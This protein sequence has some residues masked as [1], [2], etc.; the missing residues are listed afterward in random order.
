[1]QVLLQTTASAV[2]NLPALSGV[3]TVPRP[4]TTIVVDLSAVRSNQLA[5]LTNFQ[6]QLSMLNAISQKELDQLPLNIEE[7]DFLKNLIERV[8]A[9]SNYRQWDGWYPKLF[10]QNAFFVRTWDLPECDLWDALVA[11]VHTDAP[12]PLFSGDPGAVIH[13]GV[14]NVNLLLI[15]IDN[16]PNRMVYAGPVLS[17]Y[18]FEVPGVHRM[19]DDEW[20][21]EL[22]IPQKPP[23][24]EW[25]KS[26]LIP[27]TIPIPP[28]NQ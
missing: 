21:A 22:L 18:E 27:G 19:T 14:A 2:S 6:A 24:P 28:G 12:D 15:A 1:M 17:H 26:Y 16:G 7:A 5:F 3:V 8:S 11:D 23:Q 13:E 10:Y 20:K 25:T 9:Y 4:F